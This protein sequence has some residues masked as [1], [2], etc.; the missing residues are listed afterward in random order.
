MEED[1]AT[2][3]LHRGCEAADVVNQ[4]ESRRP[5]SV[6]SQPDRHIPGSGDGKHR[7]EEDHRTNE[8]H[9]PEAG[10]DRGEHLPSDRRR[11]ITAGLPGQRRDPREDHRQRSDEADR[12]LAEDGEAAEGSDQGGPACAE[13]RRA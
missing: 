5:F 13:P 12:P 7:E 11:R 4:E 3:I 6:G 8:S 9:R 10:S 2:V 1:A